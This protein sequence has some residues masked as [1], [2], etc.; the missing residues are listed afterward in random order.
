VSCHK[1]ET[2]RAFCGWLLAVVALLLSSQVLADP[3][4]WTFDRYQHVAWTGK[5]GA[6]TGV[7][8]LAQTS[9]GY[10]WIGTDHGLYRFDGARFQRFEEQSLTKRSVYGLYASSDG[11]LWI[12]YESGGV[13]FLKS[14]HITYYGSK[15]GL[16]DHGLI[17][18]FT[19]D[20]HGAI[21]LYGAGYL[22][23][24]V[25]GYFE[26]ISNDVV[27]KDHYA[28]F[29]LIDRN[30]AFWVGTGE[31]LFYRATNAKKFV[32]LE[33]GRFVSHIVQA[34]DGSIWVFA[35]GH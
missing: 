20:N 17:E 23:T 27:P 26:N 13:G 5:D 28:T 7:A 29:L 1:R 14:G 18:G 15:A 16:R 9:D 12:S 25:G 30:G 19:E 33:Q 31:G 2:A 32:L 34:S 6:P 10:L 8:S 35:R 4:P 11:G 21:W 22:Y 3:A 24:L